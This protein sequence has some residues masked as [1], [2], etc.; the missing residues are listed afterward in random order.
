[1]QLDEAIQ[2]IKQKIKSSKDKSSGIEES[3]EIKEKPSFHLLDVPDDQLNEE[4]K[5][6]KK[7]QR[8]LKSAM[9][10]R[11]KIK[12]AKDLEKAKKEEE[13][14]LEEERR[15]KDFDGWLSELKAR[16]LVSSKRK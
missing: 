3:E 5:K 8:L 1:M 6:L 15:N 9:E 16:R 7:K 11:E 13:T 4:D 2:S 14:R 12:Q 10:A